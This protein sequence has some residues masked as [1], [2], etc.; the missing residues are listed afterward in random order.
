VILTN[1]G[2]ITEKETSIRMAM[3]VENALQFG[4]NKSAEI[5]LG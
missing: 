1:C 2:I 5:K 3:G 4:K